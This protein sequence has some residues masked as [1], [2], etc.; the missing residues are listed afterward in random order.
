[1]REEC[2]ILIENTANKDQKVQ[3]ELKDARASVSVFFLTHTLSCPFSLI[4]L[5]KYV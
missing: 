1:M 2:E 5:E 3:I 4:C